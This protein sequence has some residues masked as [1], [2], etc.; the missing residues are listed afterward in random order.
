[1]GEKAANLLN[2]ADKYGLS[3]LKE[4]SEA[5]LCANMNI[6]NTLDMLVLADHYNASTLRS[7][8]LKFVGENVKEIVKQEGWRKKL[9]NYPEIIS[10]ILEAAIHH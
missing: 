10:D 2:V 8:G 9:K 7:V 5:A 3:G 1:M 6:G 4:M